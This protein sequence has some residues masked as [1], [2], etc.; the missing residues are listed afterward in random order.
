MI[1]K[2]NII[3]Y[4]NLALQMNLMHL[5]VEGRKY[6]LRKEVEDIGQCF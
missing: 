1:L 3:M 6:H 4:S 2:V 5:S